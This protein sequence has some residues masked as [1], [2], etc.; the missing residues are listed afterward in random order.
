MV[1]VAYND[2]VN[3]YLGIHEEEAIPG[4]T[5]TR[6]PGDL[7]VPTPD[8]KGTRNNNHTQ[9]EHKEDEEEDEKYEEEK[10]EG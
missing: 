8:S 10:D 7:F 9:L 1:R 4:L 6:T 5:L 3:G 2:S